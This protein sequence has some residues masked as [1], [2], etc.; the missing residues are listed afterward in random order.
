MAQGMPTPIVVAMDIEGVHPKKRTSEKQNVQKL[1]S[2]WLPEEK[3]MQL[4]KSSDGLNVLRRIGNQKRN[5]I[6]HRE[7]RPYMLAEDVEYVPDAEG[8]SG[9][10][11]VS[12]Y[13][14][15]MPLNVN[16]LIHIT[17][18]GDF[19]MVRIDGLD[20][21]HPLNL[22]KENTKTDTMDA[23]VTKVSV[24]QVADPV[25]QESLVSEN[26]P[27]PMEAEQTW[28][29]EEEIKQSNI[30]TKKKIKKVPKGWSDYQAAWIVES[31]VE[32]DGSE[33]SEDESDDDE[34]NDDEFMSCEEE[35]SDQEANEADNDFESVTE[36]VVGPTDEKYDATID[37]YEEHEML[38]K[39][40]AAKEDRQFPDEVDTPQDVPARERFMRY[41]GLESFRTS[42][43]D[44]KENLPEDYARIFQ[45]ENYERT[46]RRVFKELEDSLVNMV[47]ITLVNLIRSI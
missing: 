16:G 10:L 9:T 11:K 33:G 25:K 31:D 5:V 8:E 27:D 35:H 26:I 28:P 43:W 47:I 1:V 32:G 3:I 36:S 4:D 24:L 46:R 34:V 29:T 14:R 13:L 39:L 22:G 19:Q 18:L 7:K 15:G 37:A 17:G 40:S 6:H 23:E 20:D 21:P 38:K 45:F 2:K 30:E 42:P 12:G 41:R 44:P